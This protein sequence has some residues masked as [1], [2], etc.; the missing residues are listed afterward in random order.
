MPLVSQ[1]AD[2]GQTKERAGAIRRAN[3]RSKLT[4]LI[5][6]K[7]SETNNKRKK[8]SFFL[9]S[10][11]SFFAFRNLDSF[12]LISVKLLQGGDRHSLDMCLISVKST[13]MKR[14]TGVFTNTQKLQ[15]FFWFLHAVSIGHIQI[16]PKLMQFS[17]SLRIPLPTLFTKHPRLCCQLRSKCLDCHGCSSPSHF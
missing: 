1:S 5:S 7:P 4:E 10:S 11:F 8:R 15:L 12:E 3:G 16:L 9:S 6:K 14:S 13:H 17:S 2:Q